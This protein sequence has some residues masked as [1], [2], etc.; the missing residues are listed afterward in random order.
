MPTFITEGHAK[1]QLELVASNE[2]NKY[3]LSRPPEFSPQN[4]VSV[5]KDPNLDGEMSRHWE[6]GACSFISL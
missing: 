5:D 1:I 4:P 2:E 6:A 3:V